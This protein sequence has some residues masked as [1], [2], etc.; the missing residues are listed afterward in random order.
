MLW[1]TFPG[2]S[3]QLWGI[4][5]ICRWL[6]KVLLLWNRDVNFLRV[7]SDVKFPPLSLF[8]YVLLWIFMCARKYETVAYI[9]PWWPSH[10]NK[11]HNTVY[12]NEDTKGIRKISKSKDGQQYGKKKKTKEQTAI[13]KTLHSKLKINQHEPHYIS[14]VNSGVRKSEHFLRH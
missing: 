6:F 4:Y 8:P 3:Y 14:E 5:S 9:H 11:Y 7:L 12:I 10:R 13:Y 2:I 1:T